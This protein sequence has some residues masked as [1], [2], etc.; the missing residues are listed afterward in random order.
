VPAVSELCTKYKLD[1]PQ[2]YTDFVK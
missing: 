1:L 2:E